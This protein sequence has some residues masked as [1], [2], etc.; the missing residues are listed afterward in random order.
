MENESR[1]RY[2]SRPAKASAEE[3]EQG[4]REQSP[5]LDY[6]SAAMFKT[7]R[8]LSGHDEKGQPGDIPCVEFAQ[9]EDQDEAQPAVQYE[10]RSWQRNLLQAV[11]LIVGFAW[12]FDAARLLQ[13]S[14]IP[15]FNS[16]ASGHSPQCLA[17]HL[18]KPRP[19]ADLDDK[20]H[21]LQSE[22]Y[23]NK[24]LT[25]WQKL[26][27]VETQSADEQGSVHDDPEAYRHLAKFDT[28]L[29]REFPLVF[30]KLD[31]EMVN[32]YGYLFTW[33]GSDETLKPACYMG[34]YDTVPIGDEND[35]TYPPYSGHYDG[36]FVWGRGAL[37]DKSPL[38]AILESTTALLEAG[39]QPKRTILLSFG[40][41]EELMKAQPE[42]SRPLAK[43]IL[44]RY[45]HHGVELI[46]DEGGLGL[47]PSLSKDR[48]YALP[49][50]SEKGYLDVQITVKAQG[51]H[52]SAP[53]PHTGIGVMAAIISELEDHPHTPELQITNPLMQWLY[54]LID[55]PGVDSVTRKL[56]IDAATG[57][58]DARHRL[59]DHV[60]KHMP[61]WAPLLQTTQAADVIRGGF[62]ANALPE[63][64]TLTVN[65][66]I[67][68]HESIEVLRKH[69]FV[70][71]LPVAKRFNMHLEAF[72]GAYS[73]KAPEAEALGHGIY[74][75]THNSLEP[76][77]IS[78]TDT[79]SWAKVGLN[80]YMLLE[81]HFTDFHGL[82]VL[83]HDPPCF[84]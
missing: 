53:P 43:R 8:R 62:K 44:E 27:Q 16:S 1:Q 84:W 68:L 4:S 66:R 36:Q 60:I 33:K 21:Y 45:G 20:Y 59:A 37:D 22:A 67:A 70:T 23:A 49:S 25:H 6:H 79:K 9:S 77:P 39:F 24:S 61:I 40:F 13:S 55:D 64:T 58:A 34:H 19:D 47:T 57:D 2:Q 51:G 82:K 75:D 69:L 26:I 5:T 52:S 11:I 56:I 41:D 15:I 29:R 28:A 78:S 46:V 50:V 54:C 63:E 31:L 76:A 12:Y 32:T 81:V 42:G 38:T 71:L 18:V 17:Q 48:F 74:I 10:E 14:S 72:D 30:N 3:S 80:L 65:H 35:W 7:A 83:W 73:H